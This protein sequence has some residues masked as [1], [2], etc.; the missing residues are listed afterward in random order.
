M[1]ENVSMYSAEVVDHFNNP[2]NAGPLE[3]ADGVGLDTNPVCGDMMKLYLKIDDGHIAGASFET[4]GCPPSIAASSMLTVMV[5]GL[6][7]D[8]A[9]KI[10]NRDVAAALGGLP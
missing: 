5:E 8:D 2:R 1:A 4:R 7:L 3:D 9:L 10:K 6:S